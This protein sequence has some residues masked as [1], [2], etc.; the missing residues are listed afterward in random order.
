MK[1]EPMNSKKRIYIAGPLTPR[2]T[3][4]DCANPAIE[5]L[6]N[7]RDM[8]KAARTLIGRGWAPF[9]P[10][11]DFLYF[12]QHGAEMTEAQV[13][14]LSMAWLEASDAIVM[15]DGWASSP[16]SQAELDRATELRLATYMNLSDV[17]V[18]GGR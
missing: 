10:A 7:V 9:C 15:L 14:G 4:D 16:G 8:V 2:G 18:V 13:K 1:G 6:L 17:P 3:R 11:L 12:I 5:Y